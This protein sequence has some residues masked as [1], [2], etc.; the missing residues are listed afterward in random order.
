LK[1]LVLSSL[2]FLF[3]SGCSYSLLKSFQQLPELTD[4]ARVLIPWFQVDH[5]PILYKTSI[6]IYGNHFS[7]LMVIKP[8]SDESHRVVFI[9]EL[10]IKILDIEFFRNGD[11]RLHYCLEA[12][13]KRSV[14]RTL[15]SDLGLMI[16]NVPDRNKRVKIFNNIQSGQTVIKQKSELGARYYFLGEGASNVD[17]IIQTSVIGKKVNLRFYGAEENRID[18]VM[19]SHYNIKL[20]IHLS[21]LHENKPAVSE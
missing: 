13:N 8:V 12:L 20:N 2:F 15:K 19:I 16:H 14:I 9:T 1:N 4:P 7:G 3:L 21:A 5:N 18:S 17:A 6:D 10:G 11:F